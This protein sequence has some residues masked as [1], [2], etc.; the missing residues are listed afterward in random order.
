MEKK[1]LSPENIA[2]FKISV[3]E[4]RYLEDVPKNVFD[5]IMGLKKLCK[6]T[7][8]TVA[9]L[10]YDNALVKNGNSEKKLRCLPLL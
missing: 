3:E 9:S 8:A 6:D 7:N 1:R 10:D 2:E 4:H 5:F